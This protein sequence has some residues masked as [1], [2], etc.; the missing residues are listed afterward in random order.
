MK[1]IGAFRSGSSRGRLY[2]DIS[3]HQLT[4]STVLNAIK[5]CQLRG[6]VEVRV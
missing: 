5:K 3:A 1:L 4:N 6:T 2:K